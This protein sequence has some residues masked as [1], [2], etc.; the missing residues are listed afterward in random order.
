MKAYRFD[1][2]LYAL[3]AALT[4]LVST[5]E[6]LTWRQWVSVA[7]AGLIAIKA[8]VSTDNRNEEPI[9]T[10]NV[11]PPSDPVQTVAVDDHEI[12][13]THPAPKGATI[14]AKENN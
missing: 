3:I 11:N 12:S 1:V 2:V 4:A 13:G 5:T 8:K 6:P 9:K 14:P 10:L 7:L